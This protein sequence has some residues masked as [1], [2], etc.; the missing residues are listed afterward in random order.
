MS[1]FRLA[2]IN[3]NT[4]EQQT[5][6]MAAAASAVLPDGAEVNALTA[7]RGPSS[8]RPPLRR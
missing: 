7:P 1:R 2:L 8:S 5:T 4:N 6:E 3:P